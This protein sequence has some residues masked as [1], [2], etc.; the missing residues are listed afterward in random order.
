MDVADSARGNRYVLWRNLDVGV[1]FGPLAVQVG[2][3]PGGNI[4]GEFFPHVPGGD[5]TVGDPHAWMG[6]AEQVFKDLLAEIPRD[7]GSER[8]SGGI[9]KEVQFADPV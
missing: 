6:S 8:T 7:Q 1:F 2:N 4:I 9:A 3:C 5:E